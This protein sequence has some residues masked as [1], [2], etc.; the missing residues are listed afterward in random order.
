MPPSEVPVTFQPLGKTVRVPPGTPLAEAAAAAGL[1][2]DAP[3]GGEGT[4]GKCRV[5]VRQGAAEP[6]PADRRALP[7]DD[8]AR[9]FRL[10][11]Q[12][13]ADGAMTV[14]VPSTSLLAAHYQIL[15]QSDA[16][17]AEAD[18][19]VRKHC[20]ELPPPD[21]GDDVS[22]LARVQRA[23]R[24]LEDDLDL[25][26]ELPRLLRE[27]AFCGTAVTAEGRLLDFERGDT[28]GESYAVAVDVGTT[29]LAALLVDLNTGRPKAVAARLNPQTGFGD[30][31]LSR[32]LHS[33]RPAGLDDLRRAI[34]EAADAMIGEL[35]W[36]AAVDR[37]RLYE[38]AFA[39]NTPM[40]QLLARLHP[41]PLGE[42]PFSPATSA[43]PLPPTGPRP[44]L[45]PWR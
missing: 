24:P 29:T 39:G 26:R 28:R 7:P 16:D 44:G 5:I 35:A 25:L 4:C 20:V 2:F 10:A 17:D 45:P 3:C 8:L 11:C 19:V 38:V 30:D 6:G 36:E 1:A 40:Q 42:V 21:R 14:E 9:G 23:L 41:Q 12:T 37:R 31:V 22:D 27:N 32:I 13:A 15:A 18:P 33:Q 34:A 43:R